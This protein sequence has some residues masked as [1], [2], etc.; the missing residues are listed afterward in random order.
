MLTLTLQ[1]KTS[2]ILQ[3]CPNTEEQQQIG[4]GSTGWTVRWIMTDCLDV[5]FTDMDQKSIWQNPP[6]TS[7]SFDFLDFFVSRLEARE[8]RRT[9][10][11]R[12]TDSSAAAA[13]ASAAAAASAS[14]RAFSYS[15]IYQ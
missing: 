2:S 11:E 13:S 1:K 14:R 9:L 3:A 10:G 7:S 15:R 12:L 4:I 5:Y 6:L 8:D